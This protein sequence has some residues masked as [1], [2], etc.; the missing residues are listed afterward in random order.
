MS[1]RKGASHKARME[2][3][4]LAHEQEVETEMDQHRTDGKPE[5]NS[6]VLICG[7]SY[8]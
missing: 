1:L 4:D 6:R 5:G 2:E 3:K 8:P 7:F